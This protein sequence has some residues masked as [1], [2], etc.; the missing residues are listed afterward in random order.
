MPLLGK[1]DNPAIQKMIASAKEEIY[2]PS[3]HAGVPR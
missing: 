3:S 1:D 2:Q